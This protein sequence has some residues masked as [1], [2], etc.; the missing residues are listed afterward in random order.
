LSGDWCD[1]VVL[2]DVFV[3]VEFGCVDDYGWFEELFEW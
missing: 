2:G 3:F 1:V